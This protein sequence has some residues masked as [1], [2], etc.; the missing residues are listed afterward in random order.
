MSKKICNLNLIDSQQLTYEEGVAFVTCWYRTTYA[1][2]IYLN[3][4][5]I[6]CYYV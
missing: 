6:I 4:H 1:I 5:H 2:K 3:P